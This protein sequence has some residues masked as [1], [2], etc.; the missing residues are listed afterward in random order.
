MIGSIASSAISTP[1]AERTLPESQTLAVGDEIPSA[2]A[3]DFR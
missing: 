3:A 1:S 2:V